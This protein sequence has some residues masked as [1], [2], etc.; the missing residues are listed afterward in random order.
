MVCRRGNDS[1]LVVDILSKH[2]FS[3]GYKND[4]LNVDLIKD[5]IGGLK[6]WSNK[7]DPNFPK[8]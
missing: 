6:E 8:Y 4:D 2:F 1:Q 7:I 5:L 3:N